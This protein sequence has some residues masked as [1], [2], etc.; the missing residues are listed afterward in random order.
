MMTMMEM[1]L[2]VVLVS[3]GMEDI[4]RQGKEAWWI[5]ASVQ[6]I[7][8]KSHK[9]QKC[10]TPGYPGLIP[11]SYTFSTLKNCNFDLKKKKLKGHRRS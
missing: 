3:A 7:G 10:L 9:A 1:L 8:G 11:T 2:V 6:R 4:I 5:L